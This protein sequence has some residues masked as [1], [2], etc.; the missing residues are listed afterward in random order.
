MIRLRLRSK[1]PFA[2]GGILAV[3]LFFVG[4]LA[5][6]LRIDKP[7][8]QLTSAGKLVFSDPTKG[9]LGT[10]YALALAVAAAVVLAGLLASVLR[11]RFANF[12]P[13]AASIV[14]TI[15]L[16]IPLG[17]WAARHTARYPLGTDNIRDSTPTKIS[18]QNLMNQGEWEQ[19]AQTTAR[20][21]AW[22]TLGLASAAILLTGALEIRRR[23]GIAEPVLPPSVA[24]LDTGGAPQITGGG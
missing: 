13:A 17:G 19:S 10:I 16:L 7:T 2:V 22:V 5:F 4:L 11:S 3:P 15:L 6:G 9:T 20:Q 1:A 12:L 24:D 8:R 23:R 21:I 18:P 14:A